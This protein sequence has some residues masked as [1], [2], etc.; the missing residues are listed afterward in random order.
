MARSPLPRAIALHAFEAVAR[1]GS[2]KQAAAE[3]RVTPS[4][5]RGLEQS[6]KAS[7][8]RR[9]PRGVEL[10]AAGEI[11]F[12]YVQRAQA[13]VVRGLEA[14]KGSR[15]NRIVRVSATPYIASTVLI[16]H[17]ERG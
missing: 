7:L 15:D 16:D 9:T 17:I 3:L 10:S 4:A 5:I 12:P 1:H 6:L 11:L 14:M 8:F 2:F 13:E